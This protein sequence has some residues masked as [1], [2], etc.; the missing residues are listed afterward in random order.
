ML[1]DPNPNSLV[2][3]GD[4]ESSCHYYLGV[5]RSGHKTKKDR[6]RHSRSVFQYMLIKI[7]NIKIYQI[8]P[9]CKQIGLYKLLS[10]Y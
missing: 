9:D 7:L 2:C 10:T 8:N 5:S 3:C 6:R 1:D 4:T